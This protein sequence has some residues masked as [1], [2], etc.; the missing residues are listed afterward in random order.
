MYPGSQVL[1]K[2][3]IQFKSYAGNIAQTTKYISIT[4]VPVIHNKGTLPHGLRINIG[5]KIISYSGDTEWTPALE[6]LAKDADLFICEC[7]FYELSIKGHM[8]YKVLSE[9]LHRLHFKRIVLTHFD[10][11]MLQNLEKVTLECL[12]DDMRV[13]V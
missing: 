2:L 3:S 10:K 5:S 12:V 13:L 9:N 7:N 8:K 1:E 4:A 6:I 11:E